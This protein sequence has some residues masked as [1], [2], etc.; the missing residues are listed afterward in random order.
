MMNKTEKKTHGFGRAIE[1]NNEVLIEGQFLNDKMHGYIRLIWQ[2]GYYE[3]GNYKD[4]KSNG[5]FI[6]YKID[7]TKWYQK[8]YADGVC[9][10]EE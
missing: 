7:G 9:I 2:D 3:I 5:V 1:Q 6:A 8:E 10:K 4:G